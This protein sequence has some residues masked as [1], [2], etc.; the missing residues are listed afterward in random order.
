[1]VED[2]RSLQIRPDNLPENLMRGGLII[3]SELGI[4]GPLMRMT[5]M[6]LE[7][8]TRERVG[9]PPNL[10]LPERPVYLLDPNSRRLLMITNREPEDS[11][12]GGLFAE[13]VQL[14]D[15]GRPLYYL[16]SSD[17]VLPDETFQAVGVGPNEFKLPPSHIDVVDV[18]A[19]GK[20]KFVPWNIYLSRLEDWMNQI[21][22]EEGDDFQS[23]MRR[24]VDLKGRDR[25]RVRETISHYFPGTVQSI[26][27]KMVPLNVIIAE[28]AVATYLSHASQEAGFFPVVMSPE[29]LA[30]LIDTARYEFDMPTEMAHHLS[31]ILPT[32]D[33]SKSDIEERKEGLLRYFQEAVRKRIEE[34]G[35]LGI[36]SEYSV[37]VLTADE[38]SI[39]ELFRKKT[40]ESRVTHDYNISRKYGVL[41]GAIDNIIQN[42]SIFSTVSIP[43][44]NPESQPTDVQKLKHGRFY[45]P[46]EDENKYRM[47][48]NKIKA[49]MFLTMFLRGGAPMVK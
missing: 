21:K 19:E 28:E 36:T 8:I 17:V 27:D 18:D 26:D 6:A 38:R 11:P 1:M 3:G 40:D 10:R 2:K 31:I 20:K 34:Y 45:F 42:N 25:V 46:P 22:V 7:R 43:W 12:R 41:L 16:E 33:Q 9:T 5:G 44:W 13:V 14:D 29:Q 37:A 15:E 35:Y 47:L 24:F 49:D 48:L 32:L 39:N 23:F 30:T 4:Q